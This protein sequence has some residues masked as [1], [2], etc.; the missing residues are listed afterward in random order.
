MIG[1][2]TPPAELLGRIIS[3]LHIL[4]DSAALRNSCGHGPRHCLHLSHQVLASLTSRGGT[5]ESH[6][7]RKSGTGRRSG[8]AMAGLE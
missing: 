8:T 3:L 6:T 1:V 5:P 7:G 4:D 2:A